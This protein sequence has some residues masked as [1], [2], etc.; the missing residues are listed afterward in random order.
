M[1]TGQ[2]EM[3]HSGKGFEVFEVPRNFNLTQFALEI[4]TLRM[5]QAG[6]YEHYLQDVIIIPLKEATQL[7]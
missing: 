5:R 4:R 6:S 2:L 3:T 1:V 7:S